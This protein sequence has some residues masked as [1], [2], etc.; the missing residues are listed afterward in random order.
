M[1]PV[2]QS[3]TGVLTRLD[4]EAFELADDAGNRHVFAI[5]IDLAAGDGTLH[6]LQREGRRVLVEYE[7]ET[8]AGPI[9]HQVTPLPPQAGA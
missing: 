1:E 7:V 6:Q 3:M 4:G 8:P 5:A 9:A 2:N